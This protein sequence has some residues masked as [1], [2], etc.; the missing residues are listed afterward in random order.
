M[1]ALIGL[2]QLIILLMLS[3]ILFSIAAISRLMEITIILIYPTAVFLLRQSAN[4]II[5]SIIELNIKILISLFYFL[6]FI[7]LKGIESLKKEFGSPY[8]FIIND[9]S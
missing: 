8:K 4:L 5:V 3:G 7:I 9:L 1:Q 6:I 2:F